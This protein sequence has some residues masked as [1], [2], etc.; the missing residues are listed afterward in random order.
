VLAVAFLLAVCLNLT[1]VVGR[2]VFGRVMLS[3]DEI[4][5]FTLVVMTFLGASVVT[6]RRGH[7]RMDLV[8][9]LLPKPIQTAILA[10]EA[11]VLAAI[12]GFIAWQSWLVTK[13]MFDI[14][15]VSDSAGIPM[16][17]VHGLV[18]LGFG[19]VCLVVVCR[20]LSIFRLPRR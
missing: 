17:I 12:A 15:R 16:W 13:A 2:Y 10:F 20:G 11:I 14:G 3:A 19:L 18:F 4:Q 8:V 9:N 7:I 5:S 1:N 6:W